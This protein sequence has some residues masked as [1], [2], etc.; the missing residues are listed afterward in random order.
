MQLVTVSQ[1]S[2]CT[3]LL[4]TRAISVGIAKGTLNEHFT[5]LMSKGKLPSCL[6]FS[7][8]QRM[9]FNI[10]PAAPPDLIRPGSLPQ[11]WR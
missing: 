2:G 10:I 1:N 9:T 7:L 5:I 4:K 6:R 11:T 8:T 3:T